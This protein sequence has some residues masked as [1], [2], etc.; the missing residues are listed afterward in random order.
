MGIMTRTSNING[1]VVHRKLSGDSL[2]SSNSGSQSSTPIHNN[3]MGENGAESSN[4]HV[5]NGINGHNRAP[6]S[7]SVSTTSS[8]V[9][10]RRGSYNPN[11]DTKTRLG[12]IADSPDALV[13]P[14]PRR[15]KNHMKS[16]I[17]GLAGLTISG[18][19]PSPTTPTQNGNGTAEWINE[20][21]SS[22]GLSVPS[23]G[24]VSNRTSSSASTAS[25]SPLARRRAVF[26][27][28]HDTKTRLGFTADSP[29]AGVVIS[30]PR[31]VKNHMK[32]DIFGLQSN[33]ANY[34]DEWKL[35]AI[36]PKK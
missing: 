6:S 22:N 24:S 18:H 30:T 28:D 9:P 15:V 23:N 36:T 8:P 14:S 35:N 3:W 5:T 10:S 32:S 20:N 34:K 33:G 7:A 12:L 16:D 31:R 13:V 27:P 25:S 29:D 17:F 26:S 1:A 2:S 19:S 11:H 21:G 4:G